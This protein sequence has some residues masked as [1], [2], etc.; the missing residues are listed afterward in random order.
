M[1]AVYIPTAF[2]P[3]TEVGDQVTDDFFA[4]AEDVINAG[5]YIVELHVFLLSVAAS[6]SLTI[7][8]KRKLHALLAATSYRLL[9]FELAKYHAYCALFDKSNLSLESDHLA[10]RILDLV[11]PVLHSNR[12]YRSFELSTGTI[13]HNETPKKPLKS[14]MPKYGQAPL[15]REAP[16]QVILDPGVLLNKD[17]CLLAIYSTDGNISDATEDYIREM[18]RCGFTVIACV[19]MDDP[20]K[21]IDI[22]NLSCVDGLFVRKNSGFDFS[23]WASA[24]DIFDTAWSARRIVFTNDSIFVLPNLFSDF[25]R[26]L[27]SENAAFVGLTDSMEIQRHFQSYFFLLQ[28]AGLVNP[29]VRDFWKSIRDFPDKAQ[30]ICNYETRLLEI[31]SLLLGMSSSAIFSYFK[32][33]ESNKISETGMVNSTLFHWRHLIMSG[34]PFL[35]VGLIRDNRTNTNIDG[36]ME[37]LSKSGANLEHIIA[38]LNIRR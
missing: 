31:F 25:M 1:E 7:S 9:S 26:K 38:H 27:R 13:K 34:F 29:R 18:K 32:I 35:K 15:Y 24:L 37:F 3:L 2:D 14:N 28:G 17:V 19:A 21:K 8:Q 20:S 6:Q 4:R 22:N 11:E 30:V 33:F 16:Y 5:R 23:I 36:W 10:T 12:G